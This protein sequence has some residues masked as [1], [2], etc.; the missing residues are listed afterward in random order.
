MRRYAKTLV[1][2]FLSLA[3]YALLLPFWRIV[4]EYCSGKEFRVLNYHSVSSVRRHETSVSPQAFDRHIRCI[5]RKYEVLPLSQ[6]IHLPE[7]ELTQ[8]S[9]PLVALTFDDGYADNLYDAAPV[10]Q[11]HGATATCFIVT[12]HIGTSNLL[13]HDAGSSLDSARLMSWE[14][15]VCLTERG[16]SIGS[17]GMTHIRLGKADCTRVRDE[18]WKSKLEIEDRIHTAVQLIAFPFGRRGDY[19]KRSVT[20]AKAAGYLGTATAVYGWN[21]FGGKSFK[22]KRIGV[23]SSDTT[24]TLKAKL[25]GALDILC[26]LEVRGIRCLLAAIRGL[27]RES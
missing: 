25:N 3:G 11:Q 23:E 21:H 17:H 5:M 6:L 13:P 18:V 8:Y 15:V 9:R 7:S 4:R 22:L 20:E 2:T 24:F 10:L 19:D 12:S 14:E 27:R 16:F 26:L 1:L